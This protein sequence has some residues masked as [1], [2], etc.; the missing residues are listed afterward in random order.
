MDHIINKSN[1]QSLN[2]S[3]KVLEVFQ[4]VETKSGE[5][6]NPKGNYRYMQQKLKTLKN[7]IENKGITDS[8]LNYQR[9]LQSW[10]EHLSKKREQLFNN[11]NEFQ[12]ATFKMNQI[13]ENEERQKVINAKTNTNQIKGMWSKKFRNQEVMRPL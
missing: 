3:S 7:K 10:Q 12:I 13:K 9:P 2:V 1:M 6:I 11:Y 4:E 5:S 8:D